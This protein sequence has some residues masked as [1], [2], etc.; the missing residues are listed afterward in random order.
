MLRFV[1]L[2]PTVRAMALRTGSSQLSGH[3]TL[4]Q[5]RM[6]HGWSLADLAH[7]CEVRGRPL[8][9][10]QL[11]KLER[12]VHRPHPGNAKLLADIYET[13]VRRLWPAQTA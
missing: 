2:A 6:D 10:S 3:V 1:V 7:E 8:S 4:R 5:L 9:H 13:T 12:A 11:S